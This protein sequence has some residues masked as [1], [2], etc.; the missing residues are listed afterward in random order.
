MSCE[1]KIA[2]DL[3]DGFANV[4]KAH[5][6]FK[7]HINKR[8]KIFM[9]MLILRVAIERVELYL[10]FMAYVHSPVTVSEERV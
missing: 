7:K 4:E 10:R 3:P 5:D 2:E 9:A 6:V 1:A 8:E